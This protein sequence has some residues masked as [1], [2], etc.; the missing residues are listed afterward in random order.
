M[1]DIR[2]CIY[3]LYKCCFTSD[4]DELDEDDNVLIVAA[5]VLCLYGTNILWPVCVCVYVMHAK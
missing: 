4:T 1:Y 5:V 2:F 3:V